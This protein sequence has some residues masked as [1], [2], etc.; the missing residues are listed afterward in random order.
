MKGEPVYNLVRIMKY[1]WYK[2]LIPDSIILR[3]KFKKQM[4]YTL[5]LK[6]P[7]TF[8]EKLQWLK[9]YDR[10]SIYT[11]MVDKYAAKEYVASIIGKEYIIPTLGVWDRFDDIEFDSLPNQFVLKCTH[12][13]GGI[14]ICRDKSQLNLI[15][16]KEKIEKSLKSNFY[17]LG[18]EWP[19]KNVKPRILVEQYMED[20]K[21]KEL[22]DYKFFCSNGKIGIVLVCTNRQIDLEKTWLDED[23]KLIDLREGGHKNRKDLVK[24]D[25]FQKMK[26]IARKLSLGIPHVRVDLY[27]I[28]GEI[29]F[30]ELTFFP[31][32]GFERFDNEIWNKKL[33]D[34][35][36]LK[37]VRVDKKEQH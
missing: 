35:I 7:K 19:Y 36:D 1:P 11:T 20:A 24:P 23:F 9:L 17:W 37:M 25:N 31:S 32:G 18:R 12:D 5:N 15:E 28:N 10:K 34:M 16:A 26:E 27:E 4:G 21:E 8:N 33:G 30:G 3:L 13:S 22:R 6:N 14:V 29:F 2:K